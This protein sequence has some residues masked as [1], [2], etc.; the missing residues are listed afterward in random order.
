MAT[1][2]LTRDW[3]RALDEVAEELL[4][5]A[6]VPHPP[7]D[8]L[9]LAAR[10][11]VTVAF[12]AAQM[13]RG[14][15]KRV[16]G[17]AVILLRPD[18]RPE[19]VQWAAAHELGEA[20]AHRV[21]ERVGDVEEPSPNLREQ[22]A[23]L[24]ASRL[25]L[26]RRCFFDD[27]RFLEGDVLQL[28]VAYSTASHEL[29]ALRLLDFAEDSTVTIFDHGRITRRRS[30]AGGSPPLAPA[31]CL[32]WQEVHSGGRPIEHHDDELRVQGW[33]IHEPGWK[34]EILRTTP[35]GDT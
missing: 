20:A 26:P 7:V 3:C 17:A 8:I 34:R 18:E 6:A 2:C 35:F 23:N 25:L 15:H 28:K 29:I 19:R 12:D 30:A 11:G 10:L 5:S 16:G 21:F 13:G 4:E 14:R 24:L 32:V 9:Q 33:P 22:V 31:E 1:S 27:A